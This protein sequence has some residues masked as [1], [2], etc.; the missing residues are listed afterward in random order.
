MKSGSTSPVMHGTFCS[1]P[2]SHFFHNDYD[3]Y[4]FDTTRERGQQKE[5]ASR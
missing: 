4:I 1:A 3:T 2:L 5:P